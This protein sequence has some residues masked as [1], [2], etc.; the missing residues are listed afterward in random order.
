MSIIYLEPAL[1]GVYV[2]QGLEPILNLRFPN[3]EDRVN[4]EAILDKKTQY[5]GRSQTLC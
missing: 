4:V 2:P 3:N 5:L 1:E